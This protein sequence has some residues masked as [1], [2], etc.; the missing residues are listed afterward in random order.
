MW[1]SLLFYTLTLCF[2]K[3]SIAMLYV[4]LFAFLWL[5][6]TAQVVMAIVVISNIYLVCIIFTA[7]IPLQAYWDMTVPHT[8]C[9]SPFRD[10]P[11]PSPF[12]YIPRMRYDDL[13]FATGLR[14]VFADI[15]TS[16][17]TSSQ[18]GGETPFFF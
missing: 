8:Y 7:C 14:E 2:S 17:A 4:H 6:R 3:M 1:Y 18:C 15:R 12:S 5:R 13:V 10:T 16:K 11:Q 9:E